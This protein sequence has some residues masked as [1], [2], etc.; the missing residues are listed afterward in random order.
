MKNCD[1]NNC[2]ITFN[3]SN[4]KYQVQGSITSSARITALKYGCSDEKRCFIKDTDYNNKNYLNDNNSFICCKEKL[5]RKR[6]NIL[7]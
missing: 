4:K 6:I 7:K 2:K 5:R 1:T 3:P